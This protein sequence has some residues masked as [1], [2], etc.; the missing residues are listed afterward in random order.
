ML[1]AVSKNAMDSPNDCVL[2][3]TKCDADVK[4][5][6]GTLIDRCSSC[7]VRKELCPVN[8]KSEYAGA[9]TDLYRRDY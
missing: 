4:A 9:L 7:L 1:L 5:V 6:I 2:G 3:G 8:N